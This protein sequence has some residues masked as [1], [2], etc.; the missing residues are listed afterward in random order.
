MSLLRL[1][2]ELG[3]LLLHLRWNGRWTVL[4][5][6]IYDVL[7]RRGLQAPGAFTSPREVE[8]SYPEVS[9]DRNCSRG[10]GEELLQRFRALLPRRGVGRLDGHDHVVFA[11]VERVVL[12][13]ACLLVGVLLIH[14]DD[15]VLLI[16]AHDADLPPWPVVNLRD[17]LEQFR[18][19]SCRAK[20]QKCPSRS[21]AP[22]LLAPRLRTAPESV[23]PF[24]AVA[25]E[26]Q[27]TR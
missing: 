4:R 27:L 20:H 11:D 16:F 26:E 13:L 15:G 1:L 8:R 9:E 6:V 21:S 19:R 24:A 18:C 25:A 10:C 7:R 12:R 23:P 2:L 14:D 3:Y 17:D 5:I 22:R